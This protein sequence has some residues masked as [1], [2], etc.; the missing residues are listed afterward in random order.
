MYCSLCQ[1]EKDNSKSWEI[2]IKE[3]LFTY[4]FA[5]GKKKEDFL[6]ENFKICKRVGFIGEVKDEKNKFGS[7]CEQS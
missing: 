3:N 1:E 5:Q 7:N 4:L 2:F 6:E